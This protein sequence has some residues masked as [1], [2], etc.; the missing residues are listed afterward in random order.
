MGKRTGF[1]EGVQTVSDCSAYKSI[2]KKRSRVIRKNRK[3]SHDVT[4]KEIAHL[5]STLKILKIL[6]TGTLTYYLYILL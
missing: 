6:N 4:V 1:L 3:D 5:Q 2:H